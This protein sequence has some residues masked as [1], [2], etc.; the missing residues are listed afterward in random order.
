MA[1]ESQELSYRRLAMPALYA[2][3]PMRMNSGITVKP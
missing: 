3:C 2:T 1:D